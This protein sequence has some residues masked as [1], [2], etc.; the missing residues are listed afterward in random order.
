MTTPSGVTTADFR[1]TLTPAQVWAVLNTLITQA[2]FAASLTRA[3]SRTG[4]MAF[5]TAAPS[6]FSWLN[7]LEP[8]PVIDLG[9]DADIVVAAKIAGIIL[10]SNELVADSTVS[11][12]GVVGTLLR[13]SLSRDMDQGLL[14]GEGA[15]EPD[16]IVAAAPAVAG[17]DLLTAALTAA[18]EITDAGGTANTIALSGATFAAEAG[19]TDDNGALVHPGGSMADVAGLRPVLLPGLGDTLI[20]DS[21]RVFLVLGQ[22]STAELSSDF[23]FDR[24][25]VAMRVKARANVAAPDQAKAIRKLTVAGTTGSAAKVAPAAKKTAH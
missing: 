23:A 18:A 17:A 1:S 5:P 25:A 3:Q 7:E 24:D 12:T 4:R 21:S 19:R 15:P 8:L 2:P 22:D 13:D 10:V 11:I 16:G 20:Y 9:A 14:F 6:G